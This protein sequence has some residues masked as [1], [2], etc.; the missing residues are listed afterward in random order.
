MRVSS[1]LEDW[2]FYLRGRAMARSEE[3]D[4]HCDWIKRS[5]MN[6]S[7][8]SHL[9]SFVSFKSQ[10]TSGADVAKME[11]L[12]EE[13]RWKRK[14]AKIGQICQRVPLS[15][16]SWHGRAW[17]LEF[18]PS[19]MRQMGNRYLE[20][21]FMRLGNRYNVDVE[22]CKIFHGSVMI[23]H[24]SMWSL[25]WDGLETFCQGDKIFA[26]LETF[27]TFCNKSGNGKW[28]IFPTVLIELKPHV[29]N[30]IV[31]VCFSLFSSEAAFSTL[32]RW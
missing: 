4:F 30:R 14:L 24:W 6:R 22:R 15:G 31:R 3:V 9:V 12:R 13:D 32:E 10:M 29:L 23:V 26:S 7:F 2:W 18:C 5:P 20:F 17:Y 1:C 11:K 8:P 28:N 21:S 19:F 16:R 27:E 25:R